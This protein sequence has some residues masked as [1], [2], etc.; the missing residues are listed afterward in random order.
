MQPKQPPDPMPPP[1]EPLEQRARRQWFSA[2]RW[3]SAVVRHHRLVSGL[4]A[5]LLVGMVV[6]GLG[7]R[8]SRE[9]APFAS[10]PLGVLDTRPDVVVT[11]SSA[12]LTAL[13][14]QSVDRGESPAPLQKV[15]VVTGDGLL[16][17]KGD[18]IVLGHGVGGALEFEPYLDGDQ[19]RLKVRR[20][21]LGPLPVPR[22]I[23]RLAE[24]PINRQ[25]AASLNGLPATISSVAVRDDG[26]TITAKVKTDELPGL[27]R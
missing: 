8:C 1:S 18:V 2:H 26:L 14:Q 24:G 27:S 22:D 25:V 12:L 7:V 9:S 15:Q 21:K 5:G 17:V 11:L 20:A 16:T 3:A 4:L 19:V 10:A 13:I 6:G 23:N